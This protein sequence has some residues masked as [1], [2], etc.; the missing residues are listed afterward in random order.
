MTIVDSS[1]LVDVVHKRGTVWLRQVPHEDVRNKPGVTDGTRPVLIISDDMNNVNCDSVVCAKCTTN[2]SHSYLPNN[3]D[4]ILSR[5]MHSVILCNQI[6]TV[7]KSELKDYMYT[8]SDVAMEKVNNGL[9]SS[10]CLNAPSSVSV[11]KDK[12]DN[13]DEYEEEEEEEEEDKPIPV[14]EKPKNEI[15]SF[16]APPFS[17]TEKTVSKPSTVVSKPSTSKPSTMDSKNKGTV[18]PRGKPK[19]FWTE[20]ICKEFLD[21]Y[22]NPSFSKDSFKRKWGIKDKRTIVKRE[23]FCRAKLKK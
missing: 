17:P 11:Y 12:D 15:C 10:F 21:D 7:S 14:Q 13:Y 23:A 1:K 6:E 16:K 5:G 18:Y 3:V 4:L 20:E 2:T 8:L 9:R 19:G 22:N